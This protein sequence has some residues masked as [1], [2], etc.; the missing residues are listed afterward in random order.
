MTNPI[1]PVS[2]PG[3][4]IASSIA[5][6]D[7]LPF[8]TSHIRNSTSEEVILHTE[9]SAISI[10]E[11]SR[12]T[13]DEHKAA[14]NT[15]DTL[16]TT[17]STEHRSLDDDRLE[18]QSMQTTNY[19]AIPGREVSSRP[20]SLNEYSTSYMSTCSEDM[21]GRDID[22]SDKKEN[23]SIV[24][25]VSRSSL[26]QPPGTP[27]LSYSFDKALPEIVEIEPKKTQVDLTEA[28]KSMRGRHALQ[29]LMETERAFVKDLRILVKT[30]LEPLEEI[31]WI[32]TEHKK[33]LIRN[34][35]AILEFQ[36]KFLDALEEAYNTE[37]YT[38]DRVAYGGDVRAIARCFSQLG[39]GFSVYTDYC[40]QHDSAMKLY[41]EY[42]SRIE[43]ISYLR[44]CSSE[45]SE[46]KANSR[47]QFDDYLI[48]PVQRIC[49]YQLLLKEI[50]KFTVKG[51]VEDE[52]LMKAI[53][54]M[55]EVVGNINQEKEK[56]DVAAKT[57]LFISR[58]EDHWKLNKRFVRPLGSFIISGA[59]E[60]MYLTEGSKVKYL[61]CAVFN[62]Y[63]IIIRTKKLNQYEPKYWFPL[64]L[65][66]LTD[67]EEGQGNLMYAWILHYDRH[68]FEFSATCQQE[69]T[70]WL[71]AIREAIDHSRA[72][73]EARIAHSNENG[74]TAE[75]LLVSSL[76]DS[77]PSTPK[78]RSA[79]SFASLSD[80]TIH[81]ADTLLAD[82]SA[83][84]KSPVYHPD[85]NKGHHYSPSYTEPE[86]ST[87]TESSRSSQYSVEQSPSS[88]RLLNRYSHSA[89]DQ[90]Y[91]RDQRYSYHT[92]IPPQLLH[93]ASHSQSIYNHRHTSSID[94]KDL[95]QPSG[96]KEKM[97]Q[98][99]S[100]HFHAQRM[101]VDQKLQDVSTDNFLAAR[102]W[103][104]R[105]RDSFDGS[106]RRSGIHKTVSMMSFPKNNEYVAFDE[107]A[108]E[109][110]SPN[111]AV[112][113]PA[114][115]SIGGMVINAVKRKASLPDHRRSRSIYA[116]AQDS[117]KPKSAGLIEE[118]HYSYIQRQR[119][120]SLKSI[121]NEHRMTRLSG[122]FI[123]PSF[124]STTQTRK[125]YSGPESSSSLDGREAMSPSMQSNGLLG[126]FV[127]KFS[128]FG[129]TAK[130]RNSDQWSKA[131]DRQHGSTEVPPHQPQIS[132]SVNRRNSVKASLSS[133]LKNSHMADHS[134]DAIASESI[135]SVPRSYST[136]SAFHKNVY[137]ESAL[138]PTPN[139]HKHHRAESKVDFSVIKPVSI[140]ETTQMEK[141]KKMHTLR[142]FKDIASP[143][144][145]SG[146]LMLLAKRNNMQSQKSP[147]KDADM[148][149]FRKG[150]LKK[151]TNNRK[152]SSENGSN[153]SSPINI[154][155]QTTDVADKSR[156]GIPKDEVSGTHG[157]SEGSPKHSTND[158]NDSN[159]SFVSCNSSN[160]LTDTNVT[161]R[162]LS[163]V[164]MLLSIDTSRDRAH[165]TRR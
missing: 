110:H 71:K 113:Y 156:V 24:L 56:Q 65:F 135:S 14:F 32:P 91:S 7:H 27:L 115:Q 142:K 22:Q 86:P 15:L 146:A 143:R 83:S 124:N 1:S 10:D 49:R 145:K 58:L 148:I 150:W 136:F 46:E 139:D 131:D 126:K 82:V 121:N 20:P 104:V 70:V 128:N 5:T 155:P 129:T 34:G 87:S 60:M 153:E 117:N 137:S 2:T 98:F 16:E 130:G 50:N 122:S 30:C 48:K 163:K 72:Q 42:F 74:G 147:P 140:T 62:T 78:L 97:H 38:H 76:E 17:S 149:S 4:I 79:T 119:S 31:S 144:I 3:S 77:V 39:K 81:T 102:A 120:I 107:N 93:N 23:E 123:F 109:G 96:V 75:E 13:I 90:I 158:G 132:I 151:T 157:Y 165:Q 61:G 100:S 40:I 161:T 9:H 6:S 41:K 125:S 51:S 84:L 52:E 80:S 94:L 133:P 33:L 105:D 118:K 88:N 36:T 154:S 45:K 159:D 12:M 37:P 164:E 11:F 54:T 53:K 89:L 85:S 59:L 67:L 160:P 108:P 55:D 127:G 21:S 103:S 19:C 69:K 35:Q 8:A 152:D 134:S 25:I 18:L 28:R 101:T 63:M 47:L 99:K 116:D 112:S 111:E 57:D 114:H 66:E 141:E 95:F 73:H 68:W 138:P 26:E 92:S 106:K 29:E 162:S 64:R 43:F 44:K